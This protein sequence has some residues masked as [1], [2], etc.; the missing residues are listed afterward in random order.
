MN[1]ASPVAA[2]GDGVDDDICI[3]ASTILIARGID[4][5]R[6]RDRVAR[7]I[8][9]GVG[10]SARNGKIAATFGLYVSVPASSDADDAGVARR[11]I[12]HE[13]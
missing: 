8:R 7:D 6:L 10:R 9:S 5:R 12:H 1:E 13:V 3:A 2:I 4:E 11:M